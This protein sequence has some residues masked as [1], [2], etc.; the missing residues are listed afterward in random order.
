MNPEHIPIMTNLRVS[1]YTLMRIP[2]QRD[3]QTRCLWSWRQAL[4]QRE[5]SAAE[6][7]IAV[8]NTSRCVE[9]CSRES[10]GFEV[11]REKILHASIVFGR[12]VVADGA[13]NFMWC[14]SCTCGSRE[15]FPASLKWSRSGFAIKFVGCV[16]FSV[17]GH[18]FSVI[19]LG[20]R[21][22][23]WRIFFSL[24]SKRDRNVFAWACS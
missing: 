9:G 23:N 20:F 3:L 18:V 17:V 1:L 10:T 2:L 12:E 6:S 21:E 13:G 5:F 7:F 4:V 11:R 16:W 22:L 24:G 14:T 19:D 15:R 8:T